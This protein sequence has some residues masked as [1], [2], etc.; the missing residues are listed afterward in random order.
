MSCFNCRYGG[1]AERMWEPCACPRGN[2][3]RLRHGIS[4]K[5]VA[6]RTGTRPPPFHAS[7]PCPYRTV[8]A[9]RP[10]SVVKIHQDARALRPATTGLTSPAQPEEGVVDLCLPDFPGVKA[11]LNVELVGEL[12]AVEF[13][14]KLSGI[15]VIGLISGRG[16]QIDL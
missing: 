15:R 4:P 6:R 16:P 11:A 8:D 5:R 12:Q 9:S 3:I 13:G 1:G 10:I 2:A 14:G 7:T